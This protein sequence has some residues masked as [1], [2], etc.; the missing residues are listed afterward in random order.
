MLYIELTEKR[1]VYRITNYGL[2]ALK[3][4]E[5]KNVKID[6]KYLEEN[7]PNYFKNWQVKKQDDKLDEDL[8]SDDESDV[9]FDLEDEL[10]RVDSEFNIQFL[11]KI[12]SMRW[13]DFEDL[14]I[15]LL[16]KMGYGVASKRD[17]RVHDGGIDG[18]I[19][20]DELGLK[21]K[22]YIQA[23][24]WTSGNVGPK[25]LKEFLY[26]VG[27]GKGVFIT[28]TDFS[29]NSKDEVLRNK[30]GKVALINYHDLVRLCKKYQVLCKKQTIEIFKL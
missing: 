30:N 1:A 27:D 22:I 6:K 25:D 5:E 12:K 9:V 29:Q 24:K 8:A 13:Q 17:I 26:N 28:T 15:T 18:E 23:K 20:E 7:S 11:Q 21:G 10:D 2:S 4:A 19:F 3:D 14:C 16:E